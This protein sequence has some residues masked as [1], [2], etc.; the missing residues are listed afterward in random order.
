[1]FW[2]LRKFCDK[3][4]NEVEGE[5]SKSDEVDWELLEP[6][7]EVES[8]GIGE[9]LEVEDIEEVIEPSRRGVGGWVAI[10]R[11]ED[12]EVELSVLVEPESEARAIRHCSRILAYWSILYCCQAAWIASRICLHCDWCGIWGVEDTVTHPRG[13][14]CAQ[15]CL[16]LLSGNA[17]SQLW[18]NRL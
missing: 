4:N 11:S 3:K 15:G 18:E 13:L 10:S 6:D 17:H 8:G 14:I 1:M 9:M 16:F 5:E 2:N 12:S 7:L